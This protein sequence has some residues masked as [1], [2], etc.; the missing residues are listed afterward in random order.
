MSSNIS[1]RPEADAEL[2][3]KNAEAQHRHRKLHPERVAK[4]RRAWQAANRE[5]IAGYKHDYEKSHRVQLRAK[6]HARD[7]PACRA[8]SHLTLKVAGLMLHPEKY[9][10]KALG[11]RLRAYQV[12]PLKRIQE[13]IEKHLGDSFVIIFPRQSG[14]DELLLDLML[15]LA[16]L[17]SVLPLGIVAVNP[18][19]SPQTENALQRFDRALEANLLTRGGWRRHGAHMRLLGEM[20]L[21]FLSGDKHASVAGATASLLLIINEAQ[22]I[23]PRVYSQKFEPMAA[24]TNATRIFAG[25][26][27]TSQTLLAREKRAALEAERQ[28][29]RKRVFM[30]GAE[31]VSQCVPW[32]GAH[33]EA[34]VRRD[35]RGHPMVK[36]QYFNEEIDAQGSMFNAARRAL[37]AGENLNTKDTKDTKEAGMRSGSY[38]FLID[39]AGMDEANRGLT[40]MNSDGMGNPGRDSTTLSIVQI[41]LSTLQTLQA[42]TYRIAQRA[43]WTGLSHVTVLG[44]L[45]ALAESW[46]PQ[47]IV[48]DATGV[49]E[50]M[51]SML[52]KAFP[53]KVMP[54]KFT[55][56][57]KSDIGYRFLSII[58][59][60][61]FRDNMG[62]APP[63][64]PQRAADLRRP[65]SPNAKE[66]AHLERAGIWPADVDRQYAAC[67]SEILPGPQKTMRWGVPDGTRDENG[68][69]I[70]DD[71]ILAD[72]LV[73]E[74]DALDWTF[75]SETLIVRA[76]DP[77]EDMSHFR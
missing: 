8:P 2:R 23:S 32:Y 36:T 61:R 68:E 40:G 47:Y 18:T 13:S 29:G 33:V 6:K 63:G 14:K 37:M 3:L 19:Y 28:D 44:K 51:W 54:V 9:V 57:K 46:R 27:W 10:E 50:G 49:G 73:A 72:S 43:A 26:A 55:A 12:E 5:H 60:G 75:H 76:V 1:K 4:Q 58:E 31:E 70:H 74:L 77:L 11:V 48:V 45:Q 71:I 21:A 53:T 39:V 67:T 15:Y 62:F 34:V 42:P 30:V 66:S 17:Y 52:D 35:G 59:T 69:L 41:D 7:N 20:R 16:D 65:P 24:S 56:Q 64:L 22:D 38:A 25:T